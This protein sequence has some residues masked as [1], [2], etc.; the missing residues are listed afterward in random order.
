M[1]VGTLTHGVPAYLIIQ[2]GYGSLRDRS[3]FIEWN[4]DSTAV[5][6]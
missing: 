5:R 6:K 4:N 1:K 3:W 2:Q